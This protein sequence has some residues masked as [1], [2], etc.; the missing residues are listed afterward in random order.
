MSQKPPTT[1]IVAGQV[2]G[3][4]AAPYKGKQSRKQVKARVEKSKDT[5]AKKAGLSSKSKKHRKPRRMTSHS[6]PLRQIRKQQNKVNNCISHKAIVDIAR[7]YVNAHH[8]NAGIRFTKEALE[9]LHEATEAYI[10]DIF[11]ASNL[12]AIHAKRVTVYP[13]DYKYARHTKEIFPP[14]MKLPP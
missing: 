6:G 14:P 3:E 10:I 4:A 12:S 13:R 5:K 7:S 11:N 8:T 9:A 2:V 1:T